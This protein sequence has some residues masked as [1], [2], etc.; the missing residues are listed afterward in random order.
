MSSPAQQ[1]SL[2]GSLGLRDATRLAE[3]F[4]RALAAP[5]PVLVDCAELTEIDL[6][7]VQLLI[8]AQRTAMAAGRSLTLRHP[9]DGPL[10]R[11]LKAAGILAADGSALASDGQFWINTEARAA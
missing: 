8:S 1:L 9:V 3:D 7:I 5:G 10:E 2:K 6:A 11:L 4:E